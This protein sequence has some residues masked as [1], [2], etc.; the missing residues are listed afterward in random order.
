MTSKLIPFHLLPGRTRSTTA[1][2]SKPYPALPGM[3]QP[4]LL[5]NTTGLSFN[6]AL[7][8]VQAAP[9]MHPQHLLCT[10]LSSTCPANMSHNS[11][12]KLPLSTRRTCSLGNKGQLFFV[13]QLSSGRAKSVVFH[14][15]YTRPGAAGALQTCTAN[16]G[17]FLST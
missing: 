3:R 16:T 10:R 6:P 1:G 7:L 4:R 9:P 11:S 15:E 5:K 14:G 17:G 8:C 2:C 12:L 13:L